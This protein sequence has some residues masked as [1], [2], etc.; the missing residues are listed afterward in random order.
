MEIKVF[1]TAEEAKKKLEHYELDNREAFDGFVKSR[2]KSCSELLNGQTYFFVAELSAFVEDG[3]EKFYFETVAFPFLED[4]GF[5]DDIKS[6]AQGVKEA[7]RY[8]T[9]KNIETVLYT[10][11]N[12]D[13]PE[14]FNVKV[15]GI[16]KYIK[17][18]SQDGLNDE[19]KEELY[20][21]LDEACKENLDGLL[22]EC[23]N[24]HE[25]TKV[26]GLTEQERD[27][28][29]KLYFRE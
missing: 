16:T 15:D 29:V 3:P 25:I 8:Q 18:L 23:R 11:K 17:N 4:V 28:F 19:E 24:L 9:P 22:Q 13:E 26:R 1:K 20:R 10:V 14:G 12:H 2:G 6:L 21:D 27:E 7:I 5:Y